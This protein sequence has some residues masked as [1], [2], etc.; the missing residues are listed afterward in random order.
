[1]TLAEADMGTFDECVAALRECSLD[2]NA[3]LAKLIE[4]K[5]IENSIYD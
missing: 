4:N 1:M 3:A 2:E 5:K